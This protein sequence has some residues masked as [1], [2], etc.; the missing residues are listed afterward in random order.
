MSNNNQ[1]AKKRTPT[2]KKS[3]EAVAKEQQLLEEQVVKRLEFVAKEILAI[4]KSKE[5]KH[6]RFDV[7]IADAENKDVHYQLEFK[8]VVEIKFNQ[9]YEK[10]KSKMSNRLS[11]CLIAILPHSKDLLLS[12]LTTSD[13]IKIRNFGKTT[14]VELNELLKTAGHRGI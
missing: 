11:N 1:K 13:F 5:M 10:Y 14:H 2:Q 9:F 8:R 6:P 7:I 4:C 3:P 12:D